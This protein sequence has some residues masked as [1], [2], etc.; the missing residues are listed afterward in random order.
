MIRSVEF[1]I[2]NPAI[3]KDAVLFARG[4]NLM[5][6]VGKKYLFSAQGANRF[7]E[8]SQ[9]FSD[10]VAGHEVIDPIGS[11]AS[12]PLGFVSVAFSA[13][14]E[15]QSTLVVYEK[16]LVIRDENS[17][18]TL[19]DSQDQSWNYDSEAVDHRLTFQE[20]TQTAERFKSSVSSAVSRIKNGELSKVVIARDLVAELPTGFDLRPALTRLRNRYPTC[21]IYN[22]A[23]H[24]G[25]SPELL[26]RSSNGVVSARVLAGTAGR[27]TDPDVD[28]AIADGLAHSTKNLHEHAFAVDSLTR[29]LDP[30]CLSVEADQTPFS[31]ALPD[32]WHLATDVHAKLKSSVGILDVASALHPTAAVAG[33]PRET[34]QQLI[35]ELEVIDRG[36]YAGPVGWVSASGGGELAIALRG[37]RVDNNSLRA[38]AGCGIVSESEPDAELSETELKFRAIR[39]VLA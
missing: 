7:Q 30:Y 9:Q 26:I 34:A 19:V 20:G 2:S 1:K 29:A 21:W 35:S 18:L 25:A 39:N 27:G 16:T 11:S 10:F 3:P 24:F 37:G 12:G 23:G 28:R 5:I 31:L 33:T 22:I 4:E 36:G 8:L 38:F 32:V 15:Y 14:S 13:D 6:G 17:W